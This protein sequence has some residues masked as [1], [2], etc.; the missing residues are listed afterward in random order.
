MV[1]LL[2]LCHGNICRS[3]LAAAL[4]RAAVDADP[5]LAGRVCVA[6]AG[7]S[8]EHV[9]EGM[10]AES[11]RILQSRGLT[12]G[13]RAQQ[14]TP[15]LATSQDLILAADRSNIRAAEQLLGAAAVQRKVTL[16]RDFDPSAVGRDLD[17]PWG[18]PSE[19]Y[20]RAA[21]EIDAVIPGLL[22][23]LH[24]RIGTLSDAQEP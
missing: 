24:T 12:T 9:D 19:A 8:D 18:L 13:H 16:L 20:E 7:T 14:L 17:D 5:L 11:A 1:R 21:R 4:I 3:P 23:D 22:A 6:S 15:E 10:H 2:L